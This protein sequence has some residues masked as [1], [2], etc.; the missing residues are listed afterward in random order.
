MNY[1]V[2]EVPLIG[3]PWVVGIIAIFHVMISHFAVGGGLYLAV[4]ERKALKEG[5]LDWLPLLE[6]HSKFFLLLTGVFGAVSGVGIWFAI[7]L[8]HPEATSTLIHNFVFGW[9]IEWVFFIVELSA[10]AVYYYSWN[11]VPHALHLK[12]GWVY[13]GASICTLVIIN[14]ILTF[15]LTPGQTWLN[16]SGS[17]HESAYFWNAFFNP[18]Y[19]PSL[20]LRV[21]VCISLAG[22]WALVSF[23]RLEDDGISR[24]KTQLV[25]WSTTW[26]APAFLLMP[27]AFA[28]YY[29]MVPIGH[30]HLLELGMTTIGSGAFTQVTRMSLLVVLSSATIGGVAYLFAYLYPKDFTSSHATAILLLAL[31]AT[32]TS[33]YAR[34][35]IRKPFVIG[36]HMYS[37]GVRVRDV[38]KFNREGFLAQSMWSASTNGLGLMGQGRAMFAG[39]CMSCHTLDGYRS[40]RGFLKDRDSKAIGNILT[41]L[42]QGK[43]DSPYH[44]FMP[45][46][47]GT[48]DEV[49]ALRTYLVSLKGSVNTGSEVA[50]N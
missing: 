19:W 12:V 2:W 34:E 42:R 3:S 49:R 15:M 21:L 6:K 27:V 50:K 40:M 1:P 23:S 18:T 25:R 48:D 4:A 28:W 11:R 35:A 8:I 32:G 46:L 37:N 9:A 5:R 14:G 38:E 24:Q 47:V 43:A 41:M 26:L 31:V 44:A 20:I 33:E 36:E 16:A 39:Q 10:A 13:A 22:I 17:G 29:A 7:G 45:P 30:R